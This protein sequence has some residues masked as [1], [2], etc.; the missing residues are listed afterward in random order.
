[1]T[2]TKEWLFRFM[3]ILKRYTEN[4]ML[5]ELVKNKY[6]IFSIKKR[7]VAI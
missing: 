5:H 1:M 2:F 4:S 6:N 3:F 7:S